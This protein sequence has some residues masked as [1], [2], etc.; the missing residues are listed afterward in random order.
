M[1]FVNQTN[2]FK[3]ISLKFV[4][5]NFENWFLK[6]EENKI[7]YVSYILIN[8]TKLVMDT[9]ILYYLYFNHIYSL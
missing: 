1:N 7:Y 2:M 3:W 6:I 8:K 9:I 5:I 4:E